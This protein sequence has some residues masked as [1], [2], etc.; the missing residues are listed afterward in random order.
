MVNILLEGL[1]LD[2]DWLKETLK[3][4][5]KPYHKVVIVALSFGDEIK[6]ERDWQR[7][8]NRN[9]GG[10][11]KALWGGLS[12]YG[13]KEENISIIN[14]FTDST[15]SATEKIVNSDIAYFL[16]GLPDKM[17]DRIVEMGLLDVFKNYKGIA[18]GFS[19]GAV[20]QLSEY[21][22]YPDEDYNDFGYYKG[23]G[24]IDSFYHEVHYSG[25]PVQDESIRRVLSERNKTV[26]VTSLCK[27][28]IISDNG[29][30]RLIG[31]VKAYNKR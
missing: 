3:D 20:I 16:G 1:D 17:Y 28:A 22:L 25:T 4:Y 30:I 23:I 18:M 12:A 2:A 27:G 15:E 13:I 26:Y 19:A 10:Y 24:Y 7:E 9:D 31:E 5:I 29:E 21:H 6:N 11:Y 8:F 14:Y